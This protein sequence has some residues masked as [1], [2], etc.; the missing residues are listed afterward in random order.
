MKTNIMAS[1]MKG[2]SR[3]VRKEVKRQNTE[4]VCDL[5]TV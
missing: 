3:W 4:T 2:H 5:Q 1:G